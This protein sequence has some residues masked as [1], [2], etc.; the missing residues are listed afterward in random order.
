MKK[1]I[2]LSLITISLTFLPGCA[3]LGESNVEIAP[4]TVL[5]EENNFQLR[6][7]ERL[8]L[9]T[10]S[11]QHGMEEQRSP[12]YKLFNYISGNNDAEQDIPMTSPVFMDKDGDA[13]TAMSFVLPIDMLLEN[14]PRPQD[15]SVKLEELIDYTVATITF[16]GL[17]R[18]ENINKHQALLN[19]WI[20]TQGYTIT[21]PIKAAGY[22]PPFTIPAL[23]RNE[24]LIPVKKPQD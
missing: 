2:Y 3:V 20:N 9:V 21:G 7:Y 11:M 17:L 19:T 8:V 13:T 6:H 22:N 5:H 15:P 18:E 24:I 1:F 10:T 4:Y 12:F 14:A 23:R 16:S